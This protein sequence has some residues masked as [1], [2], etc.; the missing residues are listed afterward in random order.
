LSSGCRADRASDETPHSQTDVIDRL[1]GAIDAVSSR[2]DDVDERTALGI[3]PV[4]GNALDGARSLA[5]FQIEHRQEEATCCLQI[6]GT[7]GDVIEVHVKAP[8]PVEPRPFA[9][10][11]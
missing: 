3:E 11:E 1:G 9:T 7:D 8:F 4:A 6:P 2:A 5:F 10:Y